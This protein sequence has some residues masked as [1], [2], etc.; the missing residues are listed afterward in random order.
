MRFLNDIIMPDW[1]K[2]EGGMVAL[3]RAGKPEFQQVRND[4][5]L[6]AY[7]QRYIQSG[8]SDL[9]YAMYTLCKERNN[10]RPTVV[11][12]VYSDMKLSAERIAREIVIEGIQWY[13]SQPRH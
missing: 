11:I 1:E 4:S 2:G 7:R 9:P 13:F 5:E 3:Y 6:Y 12:H 10:Q 8:P